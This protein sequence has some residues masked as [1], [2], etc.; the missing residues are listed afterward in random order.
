MIE[1]KEKYRF[2]TELKR[3]VNYAEINKEAANIGFEY[4]DVE[5]VFSDG[6]IMAVKDGTIVEKTLISDFARRPA[7]TYRRLQAAVDL[8]YGR[9]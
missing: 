1:S 7:D 2:Y 6:N 4:G 8:F 3:S 5:Y 9:I